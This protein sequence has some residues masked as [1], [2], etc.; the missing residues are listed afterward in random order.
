MLGIESSSSLKKA[1]LYGALFQ[2]IDQRFGDEEGGKKVEAY[3]WIKNHICNGKDFIWKREWGSLESFLIAQTKKILK[4]IDGQ[5]R[6]VL[7]SEEE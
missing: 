7:P 5:S 4:E 6:N 2:S 3:N 1:E